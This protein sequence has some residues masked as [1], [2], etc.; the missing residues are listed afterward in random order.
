MKICFFVTCFDGFV[1]N[2]RH[3][4]GIQIGIEECEEPTDRLV[5]LLQIFNVGSFVVENGN[6]WISET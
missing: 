4:H 1:G 5:P 3:N 2:S 6:A